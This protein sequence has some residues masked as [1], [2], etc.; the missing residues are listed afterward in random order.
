MLIDCLNLDTLREKALAL[1]KR[2]FKPGFDQMN[3]DAAAIWVDVNGEHMIKEVLSGQYIPMPAV[4]FITA[5][6]KGG[7]RQLCKLTAIDTLLQL[8]LLD[9]LNASCETK[10]S[11]SSFAYRPGRGLSAALKRFCELGSSYPYIAKVDPKACYDNIDHTILYQAIQS[12]TADA[13]VCDLVQK[14]IAMPVLSEGQLL[15]RNKGI[16]QG[17]PISPILCNIYLHSL[18]MAMEAQ[19]IPFIRYADDIAV[20]GRS[21]SEASDAAIFVSQ[22]MESTLA[23]TVNKN[24]SKVSSAHSIRYLGHRFEQNRYNMIA[25][26]TNDTEDGA[27]RSWYR[28]Q[29]ENDH[30]ITDILSDGVLR[31]KDFT[32]LFESDQSSETIPVKNTEMLNIYSSIIFDSRVLELALRNRINF[33]FILIYL[34]V[35]EVCWDDSRP[36]FH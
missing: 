4:G 25:L 30:R 9:V 8:I 34:I 11:N 18:D 36:M 16:L 15:Q 6:Q 23:L 21:A 20:F 19:N 32:L 3:A 29:G 14:Y 33:E 22:Q 24:K 17:A 27:W 1:K 5:K 13:L 10:F 2:K 26:A 35:M 12:F 7:Y 31:Q 28:T